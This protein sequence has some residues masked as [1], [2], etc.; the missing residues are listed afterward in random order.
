MVVGVFWSYY[1]YVAKPFFD[2]GCMV[3]RIVAVVEVAD[4]PVILAPPPSLVYPGEPLY[5]AMIGRSISDD[6]VSSEDE[7]IY[8][9]WQ[10][11]SADATTPGTG[12][13]G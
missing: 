8:I 5:A 12:V 9:R 10:H 3:L 7:I 1:F 2:E 6:Y 4:R 13:G 11:L